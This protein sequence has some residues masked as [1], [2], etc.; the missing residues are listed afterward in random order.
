MDTRDLIQGGIHALQHARQLLEDSALLAS[1]KRWSTAFVLG[2]FAREEIGR[3]N[4]LL[5]KAKDL[6][7]S[8]TIAPDALRALCRIHE[9]KLALGSG[10]DIPGLIHRIC[11][12]LKAA[13]STL[14]RLSAHVPKDV[15]EF[16]TF[17]PRIVAGSA[18]RR[19]REAALYVD[20]TDDDS[21]ALPSAIAPQD[22]SAVLRLITADW[23]NTV[24]RVGG[25]PLLAPLFET[26]TDV[27]TGYD[28]FA[29]IAKCMPAF[30]VADA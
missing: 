4:L 11:A 18:Q 28:A 19:A 30:Q 5:T 16:L 14:V 9:L 21:W 25:P 23:A 20:A 1:Q 15:V 22:A 29:L 6:H 3:Y 10:A 8:G 13:P 26:I 2:L 24:L 7:P 12:D 17:S 27:P